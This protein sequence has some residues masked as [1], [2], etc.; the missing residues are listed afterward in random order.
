MDYDYT[1]CFREFERDYT[2]DNAH[3]SHLVAQSAQQL[4]SPAFEGSITRSRFVALLRCPCSMQGV[5]LCVSVST[6]RRDFSHTPIRTLAFL[7]AETLEK[8]VLLAA[9]FAECL[10]KPDN[11]TLYDANSPLAQAVES[12]YQTKKPDKFV[13][14]CK[15]L[16]K[17]GGVGPTLEKRWAIR[18]DDLNERK[19]TADA[20]P[21]LIQRNAPFLLAL[22]DRAPPDV[23]GSLHTM[24]DR[25]VVRIFSKAVDHPEE[26]LESAS[27]KYVLAAAIGGIVLVVL[28]L[29]AAVRSCQSDPGKDDATRGTNEVT[30]TIGD[31][32]SG[33]NT[34]QPSGQGGLP[35]G[36]AGKV[37]SITNGTLQRL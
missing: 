31:G 20:L 17:L 10:R 12:L 6:N 7:R 29:V 18:R 37:D 30:R 14:F 22:T 34:V 13:E 19:K 27:Q 15:S 2:W 25:G 16:P 3:A 32:S 26:L 35:A 1:V 23:L 24:F 33:T 5:L 4:F 11:E 21:S 9:F 36:E 8:A 28:L